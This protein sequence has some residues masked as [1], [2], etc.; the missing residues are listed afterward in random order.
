MRTLTRSALVPFSAEQM[1][2]LVNDI[3]RYP[4]FL[5]WC[6]A[7]EVFSENYDPKEGGQ[8]RAALTI[9]RSRIEERFE[10]KNFSKFPGLIE[11]ELVH[12]PFRHLKGTWEFKPLGG[13]GSKTELTLEYQIAGAM[14]ERAIMGV[15]RKTANS[16][17]DAF[18]VRAAAIYE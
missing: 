3:E 5:P 14:I 1:F 16:M 9:R 17:V 11:I 18:C 7:A 6:K 2:T 4:E 15:V 12:G 8:V 13:I 10:T